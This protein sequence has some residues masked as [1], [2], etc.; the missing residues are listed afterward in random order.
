MDT[1]DEERAKGKT[2]ECGRATFR[3]QLRH[4]TILDAPGHKNFVPFMIGGASQAEIGVL[5]VSSRAGEFE[6]GF[7]RGGQTREHA[8]LAKTAG[9]GSL[10]VAVNKMDEHNWSKDRWDYILENIQPFLKQSGFNLKTQVTFIP[11][12][13]LSGLNLKDRLPPGKCDWYDGPSLLELLDKTKI[14][15]PDSQADLRISVSDKCVPSRILLNS[16]FTDTAGFSG[17]SKLAIE[18]CKHSSLHFLVGRSQIFVSACHLLTPRRKFVRRI[19]VPLTDLIHTRYREADLFVTGKIFQ[20]NIT[21]GQKILCQPSNEQPTIM[22]ILIDDQAQDFAVAGDNVLLKIRG[23]EDEIVFPGSVICAVEGRPCP[24]V[25]TFEAKLNVLAAK[26]I[27]TAGYECMLHV[28]N[29]V[30]YCTIEQVI[31]VIDRNTGE[32]KVPFIRV[33]QQARVRL[34]VSEKICVETYKDLQALGR[35]IMREDQMTTAIGVITSLGTKEDEAAREERGG[36][37]G[38]D[39]AHGAAEES[40]E[41]ADGEGG[42]SGDT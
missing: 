41:G 18:N 12:E 37:A 38:Q 20:G 26:S 7:E 4:Y 10:I 3:T 9:V 21:K 15:L 25:L 23:V 16:L 42:E 30:V 35:F 1:T 31:S 40:A 14:V 29:S 33:G 17:G 2:Q 27:M 39:K 5:V 24:V 36:L 34:S 8:V 22:E 6:A 19:H 13:G 28:H 11:L 32:Q